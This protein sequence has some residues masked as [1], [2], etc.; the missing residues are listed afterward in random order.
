VGIT[1][2]VITD[3]PENLPV[4]NVS[5]SSYSVPSWNALDRDFLSELFDFSDEI[6]HDDGALLFFHPDD[7]GDVRESIKDHFTAFGFTI[8]KNGWESTV[9]AY[10]QLSIRTRPPTSSRLY[11]L[12]VAPKQ[13]DLT[14][15]SSRGT[16]H[17]TFA[18]PMSSRL[19]ALSSTW[20]MR[21]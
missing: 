20:M 4:P 2:L 5:D 8:F 6:L 10:L 19:L 13:L 9:F 21:L 1:N 12:F 3:I 16:R 14:L 17:F 18:M 11:Y 7:N 15:I